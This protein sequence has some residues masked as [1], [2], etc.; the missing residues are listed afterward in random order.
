MTNLFLDP[1]VIILI[2]SVIGFVMAFGIGANDVANAMGTSV[3][4]KALTLKQAIIIAAI[5]EFLGAYLAGGEVT[6]T[7]RKGIVD[8]SIYQNDPN[9]FIIGML[10]ASLGA[11]LWLVL[12]SKRGWPVSTTH[13]IVG[14]IIGFVIIS[15]GYTNV[16]WSTVGSIAS[17]W[18]TSPLVSGTLAFLLFLSAKK[19]I[20]DKKNPG[21]SAIKFIPIYSFYVVFVISLVV[22]KKGLSNTGLVLNDQEVMLFTI[23][24]STV[25]AI[26]TYILL[27]RNSMNIR[28][29]GVESA[30]AILMIISASAM[31]FAHGS[32]DVA[33]AIGP[34]SAVVST[35]QS[36]G[37]ISG[38]SGVRPW[39]LF[40]G[41][42]GIVFGLTILGKNVIKTVG[43]NITTLTPS[44]G[45]SAELATATTVVAASYIGFPIST[46]HTLVGGVI[47]V[48]LA[49][50]V[51]HLNIA[52]IGRIITSWLV[53]IPIGATLC[54]LF[55]VILR[56][57]FN[58]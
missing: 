53:T 6:S 7:I 33:N 40:V 25:A 45:F 54:I 50:G 55:Y 20:L 12:A 1:V 34:L 8:P 13:S 3:G 27:L 21:E 29:N 23:L 38:E 47:G 5:F 58:V 9:I 31:A 39:V 44:L 14:A 17:S 26:V 18:V 10:S 28:K 30:F 49:K 16:S 4:S 56:L 42:I 46:T 15:K 35:V 36:N 57:I 52:S 22:A 48:G 51:S 19:L 2:A 11:G 43:E 41:A 32:N 37:V 24:M